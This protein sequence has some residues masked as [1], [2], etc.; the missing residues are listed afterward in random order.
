M[1][2]WEF[3]AC[4]AV[5]AVIP[6]QAGT[7]NPPLLR[8]AAWRNLG[9]E[10]RGDIG[11]HPTWFGRELGAALSEEFWTV[12]PGEATAWELNR[13][14]Q[15]CSETFQGSKTILTPCYPRK[16]EECPPPPTGL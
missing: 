7:L 3:C 11:S 4:P 12:S 9:A 2:S 16:G 13:Q 8:P 6:P 10:E 1:E 5:F 15:N 14:G